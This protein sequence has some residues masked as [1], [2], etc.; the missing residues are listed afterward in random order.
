MKKIIFIFILFVITVGYIPKNIIYIRYGKE[1]LSVFGFL[2]LFAL[3]FIRNI[4]LKLFVIWVAL[5]TLLNVWDTGKYDHSSLMCFMAYIMFFVICVKKI[6]A[7]Y[8]S[9]IFNTICVLVLIEC[10]IIVLQN[11]GIW[12]GLIDKGIIIKDKILFGTV[13]IADS[14]ETTLA[15]GFRD[16][17]LGTMSNTNVTGSFLALG[18]PVF[19][20]KKWCYF[21]PLIVACLF[22]TGSMGGIL[23]TVIILSLFCFLKFKNIR[24]PMLL[25]ILFSFIVYIYRCE[26]VSTFILGNGRVKIWCNI[27][28]VFIS[29]HPIIGYGIGGFRSLYPHYQRGLGANYI[30][31]QAHSE[32]VQ[33][34]FEFG[35][36][37]LFL[38]VGFICNILRQIKDNEKHMICFYGILVGLIN[39]GSH[40]L[41]H[42]SICCLMI[43]YLAVIA[44][45]N[46]LWM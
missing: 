18:M 40:F 23:P 41:F 13:V 38:V 42:T 34:L 5:R 45:E 28:T 21:I 7:S 33:C 20:R 2:V 31:L 22:L 35:I 39:C 37:G 17:F 36:I 30:T 12:F 6:K 32:Y 26:N 14:M 19:F 4:W 24:Y 43:F 3:F 10:V 8:I 1:A 16:S 29:K 27:F 11:Y 9:T 25:I 15:K 44:K 46:E